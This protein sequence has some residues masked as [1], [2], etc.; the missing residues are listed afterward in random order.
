MKFT[1]VIS[2]M[3]LLL[4]ICGPATAQ[5]FRLIDPLRAADGQWQI[6][7]SFSSYRADSYV[8]RYH[9]TQ[10]F[11]SALAL[12]EF[13]LLVSGRVTD[14]WGLG[15]EMPM[16]NVSFAGGSTAGK[17]RLPG[18]FIQN[19]SRWAGG[20]VLLRATWERGGG[21]RSQFFIA[22]D[23]PKVVLLAAVSTREGAMPGTA[24]AILNW[25]GEYAKK[26]EFGRF[27]ASRLSLALSPTDLVLRNVLVR[28][29][30]LAG[31]EM[32]S[33]GQFAGIHFANR[34]SRRGLVGGMLDVESRQS[35][36]Q[37]L[38]FSFSRDVATVNALR[39][40]S[41]SVAARRSF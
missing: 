1:R 39:G 8:D 13:S 7:T 32:R 17:A 18:V 20:D 3:V 37:S 36:A 28:A 30:A 35:R 40:W 34:T 6:E 33:S 12:G 5:T 24:R 26:D 9:N 23:P 41:W 15:A 25:S 22:S 21:E 27:M 16:S 19:H 4:G 2:G 38:T 10:R 29:S 14:R 31:F 11:P